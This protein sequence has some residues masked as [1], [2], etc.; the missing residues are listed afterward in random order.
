M[1]TPPIHFSII[2]PTLNEQKALPLLLNDL[3]NQSNQNFEIIVVDG[4]SED[5]TAQEFQKFHLKNPHLLAHF[6][7]ID[8]R[9][10]SAQRNFGTKQAVNDWLVFMDADNRLPTFFLQGLA[11][12]IEKNGNQV[13]LFSTLVHLDKADNRNRFYRAIAA[14]INFF[15]IS[16]DRSAQPLALGALIGARARLFA[17]LRFNENSK[18]MEDALFVKKARQLGFKFKLFHEPTFA[19]SMRRIKGTGLFRTAGSSFM[20]QMRYI[21]GDEFTDSDYGYKMLGGQEYNQK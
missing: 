20:M 19:Y 14:G 13:D 3:A 15:V 2:I 9:N 21:F 10:V 11:Y 16:R 1:S 4:Q 18:V 6:Y 7:Q 5:K 12:Q 8:K 17:K